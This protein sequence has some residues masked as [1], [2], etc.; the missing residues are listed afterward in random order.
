MGII[1]AD[2]STKGGVDEKIRSF[3]G[4]SNYMLLD[5]IVIAELT[6]S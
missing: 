5:V 6:F 3:A 2:L 1:I 4:Y